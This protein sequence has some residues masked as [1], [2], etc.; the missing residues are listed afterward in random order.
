MYWVRQSRNTSHTLKVHKKT[1]I[2]AIKKKLFELLAGAPSCWDHTSG[3]AMSLSIGSRKVCS[4]STYRSDVA[5]TK[6]SFFSKCKRPIW[7]CASHSHS[8]A[9]C[10]SFVELSRVISH[11]VA[12]SRRQIWKWASSLAS[13]TDLQ[14]PSWSI[15]PQHAL[16]DS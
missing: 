12:N 6:W 2:N 16:R 13:R 14:E 1:R 9:V 7:N 4:I 11:P 10:M 8:F 5:I 15:S 3:L